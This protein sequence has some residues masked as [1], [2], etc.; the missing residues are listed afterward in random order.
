MKRANIILTGFM[1]TGKTTVGKLLARQMDYD[2]VD[3]DELIEARQG[4]SVAEIFHTRGEAAFRAL[5]AE[6]ARELAG[7]EG[8]V[9]A[10][11]GRLMLDRDNAETL[12]RTGRIFCLHAGPE[13]ILARVSR[14]GGPCRP[15]LEGADPLDAIRSLLAQRAQGYA[16][17]EKI[18]TT[19]RTPGA[20]VQDL[21]AALGRLDAE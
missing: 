20:V 15:L 18:E 16:R 19:G 10:T 1:G 9:I 17:F 7:R 12:G 2:F 3:T 6:V 11:G 13:E 5:E 14:D 4:C 21:S 8:L